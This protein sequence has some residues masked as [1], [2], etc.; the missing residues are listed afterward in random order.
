MNTKHLSV[1]QFL[2]ILKIVLRFILILIEVLEN[3]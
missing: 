3:L 2:K 1:R